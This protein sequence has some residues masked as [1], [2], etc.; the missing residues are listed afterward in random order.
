MEQKRSIKGYKIYCQPFDTSLKNDVCL[1]YL[2]TPFDLSQPDISMITIAHEDPD[3][4]IE[5]FLSGWG[6]KVY[7]SRQ[8]SNCIQFCILNIDI[9]F[10][11]S[12]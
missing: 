2:D 8:F 11:L 3:Q 5:C 4:S 9:L 10:S 7:A 6:K 12:V 1:L